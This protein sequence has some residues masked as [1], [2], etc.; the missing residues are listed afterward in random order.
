MEAALAFCRWVHFVAAM[1]LFGG[2]L[3]RL[4]LGDG[5]AA[6]D[7]L[8]CRWMKILSGLALVSGIVWLMLEASNMGEGWA[9]AVNLQTIGA[10]AMDTAFGHVWCV[11]LTVGV[12]ICLVSI[13]PI[14]RARFA[15]LA[16]LSAILVASIALTGHAAMGEGM[17][18]ILHPLNQSVHLLAGGG[19]IGAL[20]PLWLRLRDAKDGSARSM[21]F[22]VEAS[23]RF[24]AYGY[25]A[26]AL[27]IL[28][29]AAESWFVLHSAAHSVATG[30]GVALLI[31]LGFVGGMLFCATLNRFVFIPRPGR[32][33][34]ALAMLR[35]SVLAEMLFAVGVLASVS[36]LGIL[37]PLQ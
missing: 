28:S 25:A 5:D 21:T 3:F 26:V 15:A 19:W 12:L 34:T 17:T 37:P 2:S 29:G 22:A 33:V 14:V 20:L 24:A 10:V 13:M 16:L 32:E 27:V 8:L 18:A 35:R 6:T 23:R 11:R 1:P 30:Y 31:K 7:R 4:L 9:D 36:L